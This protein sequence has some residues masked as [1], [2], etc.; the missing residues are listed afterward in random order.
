LPR[1]PGP[2]DGP[3]A[4][5]KLLGYGPGQDHGTEL[6]SAARGDLVERAGS[7]MLRVVVDTCFPLADAAKA[8]LAGIAGHAPGKFV[9][10]P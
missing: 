7:G 5:I 10:I 6:R 9:L 3:R 4:D 1:S 8:H 2:R